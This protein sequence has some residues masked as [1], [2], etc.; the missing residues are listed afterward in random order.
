MGEGGGVG[1]SFTVYGLVGWVAQKEPP[2]MRET[3]TVNEQVTKLLMRL[4]HRLSTDLSHI[5]LE[6]GFGT[7]KTPATYFTSFSSNKL[8]KPF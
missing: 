3:R 5:I 1:S 7:L 4:C 8:I 2:E 6:K